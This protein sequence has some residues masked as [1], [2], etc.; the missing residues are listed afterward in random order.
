MM[1]FI[2]KWRKKWRFFTARTASRRSRP[3]PDGA[4]TCLHSSFP[5]S[6]PSLS[7]KICHSVFGITWR[8]KGRWFPPRLMVGVLCARALCPFIRSVCEKTAFLSHLY[9]FK[10][11]LPRQARDK[12]RENSNKARQ[13]T[14]ARAAVAA[15]AAVAPQA[16]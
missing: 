16:H 14:A 4:D 8:T 10:I 12:H 9:I 13:R 7:W 1:Y 6:I 11:I 15:G 5:T 2:Y 3:D